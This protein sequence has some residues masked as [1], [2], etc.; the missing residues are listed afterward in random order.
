MSYLVLLDEADKGGALNL[1]GVAV[2][3]EERNDKVKEVALAQV[4]RRLLLKVR[5]AEADT[6]KTSE[7]H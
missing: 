1:H 2:F 5:P 3:V 7:K 4:G 6:A